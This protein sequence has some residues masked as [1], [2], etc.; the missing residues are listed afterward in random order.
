M[1]R[2]YVGIGSNIEPRRNVPHALRL[3]EER[4]GPLTV[5]PVYECPAVGFEGADFL[6][7][8]VGFDTGADP[9]EVV[10]A[11]RCIEAHCGR[12]RAGVM[13]SRTIDLDFLLYDDLVADAPELRLPRKDLLEYGFVLKPM[14]DIAGDERHPETGRTFAEHWREFDGAGRDIRAIELR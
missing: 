14:V 13:A 12:R 8:V 10:Q 9:L 3:L 11:L 5:S 2:V 1:S 6:N 7:L 4:F